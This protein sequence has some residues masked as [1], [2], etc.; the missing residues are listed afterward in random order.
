MKLCCTQCM[1]VFEE[2]EL[3]EDDYGNYIC[4]HCESSEHIEPFEEDEEL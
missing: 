3:D 2:F 1:D 4:P